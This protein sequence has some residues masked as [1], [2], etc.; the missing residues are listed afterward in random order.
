MGGPGTY[1]SRPLD[2]DP[3][4]T[5]NLFQTKALQRLS[6]LLFVPAQLERLGSGILDREVFDGHFGVVVGT[7]R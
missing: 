2:D 1:T 5:L 7:E 3:L 4:N 6:R